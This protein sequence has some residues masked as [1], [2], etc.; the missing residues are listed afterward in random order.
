MTFC[1]YDF[2]FYDFCFYDFCFYGFCFYDFYFYDFPIGIWNYSDGVVFS[3]CFHINRIIIEHLVLKFKIV[4]TK[5][6][7]NIQ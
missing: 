5:S 7:I 4:F 6:N 3:F 1:F 2:C